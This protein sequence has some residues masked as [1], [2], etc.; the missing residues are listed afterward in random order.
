MVDRLR[1]LLRQV[2]RMKQGPQKWKNAIL[3]SLHK[4]QSRKMR[5]NYCDSALLGVPGWV[6]SPILHSRLQAITEPQHLESQCGFRKGWG[7]TDQIWVTIQIIEQAAEYNA[8][9]C[10]IDL[11][12]VYDSVNC[13]ALIAILKN[14][15]VHSHLVNCHSSLVKC[16]PTHGARSG[17]PKKP[18]RSALCTIDSQNI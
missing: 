1:E 13:D 6:L 17:L 7:T 11:T 3:I 9:L 16:T 12:K 2:W 8:H 4:K 14:N 15:K 18:L 10:F 5:G